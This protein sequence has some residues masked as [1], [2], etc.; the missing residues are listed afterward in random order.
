[1]AAC[2]LAI[3]GCTRSLEADLSP[4]SEPITGLAQAEFPYH[5]W[6]YHLDLSILAYHLYGQSL[7]WPYDPYYEEHAGRRNRHALGL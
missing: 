6:V 5:P 1:M 7:V 4:V 2:V 3:S